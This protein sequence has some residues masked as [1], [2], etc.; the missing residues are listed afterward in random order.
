MVVTCNC[1]FVIRMSIDKV[2]KKTANIAS[3]NNL[4]GFGWRTCNF[5]RKSH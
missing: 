3:N 4:S 5:L 1:E 2:R